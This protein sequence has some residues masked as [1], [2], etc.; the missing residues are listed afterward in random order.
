M[1]LQPG[2]AGARPEPLK[3]SEGRAEGEMPEVVTAGSAPSTC[4]RSRMACLRETR[5]AATM[6]G[7]G[8]LV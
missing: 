4:D 8:G 7:W 2:Y 5:F 1:L 3:G 6:W